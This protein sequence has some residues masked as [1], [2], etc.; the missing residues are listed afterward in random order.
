MRSDRSAPPRV[1]VDA[2]L[3]G[4]RVRIGEREA[5]YLSHVLRLRR[6][7]EIVVFNGQGRE[8]AATVR[9]LSRRETELD[10]GASLPPLPEPD[11]AIV[12]L[13]GLVKSDAMDLIVQK[14]TE[15]GVRRIVGI[16]T[17][18]SVIRLD[19]DRRDKRTE[20]WTRIARSACE[21]SHRHRPPAIGIERSLG[22]ALA[23]LPVDGM[24]V[25]LDREAGSDFAALAENATTIYL[26]VG[27]EGGFSPPEIELLAG[28]GF[29]I[30]SL[31]PRVL[32]AET[33]ALAAATLAQLKWGDLGP[34]QAASSSPSRASS[35]SRSGTS[36]NS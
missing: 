15:L 16:R 27:P 5:H 22:E 1:F 19:A 14:A 9:S 10:L 25:A 8:R 18:Y 2:A 26:A 11:T 24:R 12:L 34:A 36:G 33:A 32:R 28:S 30:V 4:D 3:T 7:S 20:H 13:Q 6:G 29:E 23:S 35:V 31:G 21:Q 17:D